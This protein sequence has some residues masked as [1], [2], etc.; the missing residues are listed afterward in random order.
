M[1]WLSTFLAF[2]VLASAPAH[3]A[4]PAF[5]PLE[6]AGKAPRFVPPSDAIAWEDIP[7]P[8][9]KSKLFKRYVKKRLGEPMPPLKITNKV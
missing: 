1:T 5:H 9:P 8:L 7:E 2:A 3:A 6:T 4:A